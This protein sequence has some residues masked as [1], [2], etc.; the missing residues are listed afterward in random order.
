MSDWTEAW[1]WKKEYDSNLDFTVQVQRI[2]NYL[3]CQEL[4]NLLPSQPT[5]DLPQPIFSDHTGPLTQIG[6]L[7]DSSLLLSFNFPHT[8]HQALLKHQLRFSKMA[9]LV[10][11]KYLSAQFRVNRHPSPLIQ[12]QYTLWIWLKV[13][14]TRRYL[15]GSKRVQCASTPPVRRKNQIMIK[16]QDKDFL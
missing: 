6:L 1:T 4:L 11:L 7:T 14:G 15:C 12:Y 16:K 8:F 2:L 13:V 10:F 3:L 5:T 9:Y